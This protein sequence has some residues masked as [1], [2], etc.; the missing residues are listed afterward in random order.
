VQRAHLIRRKRSQ[1]ETLGFEHG[2]VAR[3]Y[4]AAHQ[5]PPLAIGVLLGE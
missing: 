1:E 3:G 5:L 4:F 2:R